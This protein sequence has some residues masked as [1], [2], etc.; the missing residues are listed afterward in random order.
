ML[1]FANLVYIISN[2]YRVIPN[3]DISIMDLYADSIRVNGRRLLH[4][5]DS[6]DTKYLIDIDRLLTEVAIPAEIV[7]VNDL[8][9]NFITPEMLYTYQVD[10]F[11]FS[12]YV[13]CFNSADLKEKLT[14]SEYS[15]AA[16]EV[17]EFR[18]D[19]SHND[20]LLSTK[21]YN[22]EKA[23]P[24]IDNKLRLCL[25]NDGKIFIKDGAKLANTKKIEFLSFGEADNVE[26]M[27]F[28][29]LA[30]A[31]WIVDKS[32]VVM[33]VLDGRLF[34]SD[35]WVY[36]HEHNGLI[37]LNE[38]FIS[39]DPQFSEFSSLEEITSLTNSFVI[40]VECNAIYTRDITIFPMGNDVFAF[41]LEN[42]PKVNMNYI[43]MDNQT[44]NVKSFTV[45]DSKYRN[46]SKGTDPT[47]RHLYIGENSG[48]V[49]LMQFTIC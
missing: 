45:V 16:D 44:Y 21:D 46:V 12:K 33:L 2:R 32:R 3:G 18:D 26:L 39:N 19:P 15:I 17:A 49:K 20:L 30:A 4:T 22:L 31:D 25:W 28:G 35:S 14:V 23:I 5:V 13:R 37:K 36:K 38:E 8:L 27:S 29:Q 47:E 1:K 41:D 48:D 10:S 11:N 42:E 7:T 24:V 40:A 9:E 43:C 34:Y 6:T